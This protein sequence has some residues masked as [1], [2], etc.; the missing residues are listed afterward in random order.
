MIKISVEKQ[1]GPAKRAILKGLLAF[2]RSK[3]GKVKHEQ[4]VVALREGN[5]IVGGC[6]GSKWGPTLFV[7]LLWIDERFRGQDFGTRLMQ[8]MEAEACRLGAKQVFLDTIEFQAKPFYEKLG[9]R[10]F[11]T[12]DNYIDGGAR[13][14]LRKDL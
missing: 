10:V 2:N 5:D 13:Y 7:D 3:V 11:G 14:W 8:A 1:I 4:V 9:Y 6:T 12:L